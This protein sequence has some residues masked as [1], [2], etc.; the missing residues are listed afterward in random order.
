MATNISKVDGVNVPLT[1]SSYTVSGTTYYNA[2]IKRPTGYP[3][4]NTVT[5][6]DNMNNMFNTLSA[7]N[8]N[9]DY[10][11]SLFKF[12]NKC[13]SMDSAFRGCKN[14]LGVPYFPEPVINIPYA[15]YACE[16]IT[17]T[18]DFGNVNKGYNRAEY[19]FFNC[20]NL[21]NGVVTKVN[22]AFSMYQGCN[23]MTDIEIYPWCSGAN[24]SSLCAYDESLRNVIFKGSSQDRYN[25]V[26]FSDA[27]RACY[28]L[29]NIIIED[30]N[31]LFPN[32]GVFL[33]NVFRDC[34]GITELNLERL[35]PN[36]N[37]YSEDTTFFSRCDNAFTGCPNA[38]GN[39]LNFFAPVRNL[40]E[41]PYNRVVMYMNSAFAGS[42]VGIPVGSS[43][44]YNPTE[45]T[46]NNAEYYCEYAFYGCENYKGNPWVPWGKANTMS[47]ISP[48]TY[49]SSM[50]EDCSNL[51]GNP[52]ILIPYGNFSHFCVKN[53]FKNTPIKDATIKGTFW[54]SAFPAI[55]FNFYGMLNKPNNDY[56]GTTIYFLSKD[57]NIQNTALKYFV[58]EESIP[59][60][61]FRNNCNLQIFGMP[62]T[63]TAVNSYY[64]RNTQYNIV[65]KAVTQ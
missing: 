39:L 45:G 35:F 18:P 2:R 46:M 29:K 1:Y 12:T 40:T 53:I 24:Y 63:Y 61:Y 7:L 65:L 21:T 49:L 23:N 6:D 58:N 42:K 16:S 59:N 60:Q 22:N 5:L 11:F 33:N 13:K 64:Y 14:L 32:S 15:Y 26:Y 52:C 17:G 55:Q 51:T 10:I 3:F 43:I 8:D 50:Y 28:E 31:Y 54:P 34:F 27:F 30:N 19:A 36:P 47:G 62:L 4:L 37:T 38:T 41:S 25:I 56:S 44:P 20:K 57:G 48:N 9:V